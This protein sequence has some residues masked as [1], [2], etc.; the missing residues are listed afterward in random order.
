[1]LEYRVVHLMSQVIKCRIMSEESDLRVIKFNHK[2]R[3][4]KFHCIVTSMN[5]SK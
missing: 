3:D 1:M 2:R 5:G 4:K